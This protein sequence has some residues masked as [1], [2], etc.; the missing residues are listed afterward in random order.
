MVAAHMDEIGLMVSHIDDDGFLRFVPM[1]G[2]SDQT[3]LGQRVVVH[4]RDGK[5][6]PGVVGSRPPHLMDA[7]ERKKMVKIKDMFVDCGATSAA[8]AG[9]MGIEIGSPITID[10]ELRQLGNDFVTGKALDNRAGV[11]HDGGAP[12]SC[13]RARTSRPRCRRSAPSRRR[14]GLK[15][16]RTSAYGLAP[17]VAIATDVTI[18]GDHPGVTQERVPRGRR[19]RSGH[20][21]H[22]RRRPGRH[23]PAA[24]AALAP[25]DRREGRRSRISCRWATAATPTPPPSASPRPVSPAAWSAYPRAIST[26]RWRCFRCATWSRG[27]R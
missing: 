2:W 18:P 22:R 5:R 25:G 23:R 11:R 17:D 9:A 1:G 13:S 6:I 4:T 16:A 19:Q 3:I 24:G 8:N 21:R 10:R 7:E 12:C 15:G 14:S 27:P 26:R 20:H